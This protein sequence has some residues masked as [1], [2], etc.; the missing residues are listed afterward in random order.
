SVQGQI[1]RLDLSTDPL[2]NSL[3]LDEGAE[4][5]DAYRTRV[6]ALWDKTLGYQTTWLRVSEKMFADNQIELAPVIATKRDA[7]T[8]CKMLLLYLA[9]DLTDEQIAEMARYG[10]ISNIGVRRREFAKL[11]ELELPSK[12]GRPKK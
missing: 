11:L 7:Q 8:H 3:S 6:L 1:D 12:R 2:D 5:A 4:S 9:F 10:D